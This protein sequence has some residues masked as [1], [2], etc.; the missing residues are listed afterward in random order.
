MN[1]KKWIGIIGMASVLLVGC[2]EGE[3]KED[4]PKEETATQE[5]QD[6]INE[7]SNL[8]TEIPEVV[9]PADLPEEEKEMILSDF[10]KYITTFNEEDV[11]GY[12]ATLSKTPLNFSYEDEEKTVRGLFSYL[13]MNRIAEN[14]TVISFNGSRADV[15]ADMTAETTMI[16]TG[17]TA[18]KSGKQVTIMQKTDD[19]WKVSGIFFQ[20]S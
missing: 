15:Y 9:E 2:S 19:G 5:E 1:W 10:N 17:E 3:E 8:L 13:D 20:E 4:Q 6:V 12:M 18:K 11:D 14:V 16:E 7:N